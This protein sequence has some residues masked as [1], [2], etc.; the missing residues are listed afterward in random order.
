MGFKTP[1]MAPTSNSSPR[2][3]HAS[4]SAGMHPGMNKMPT[5][6]KA[7]ESA[8]TKYAAPTLKL[9][10]HDAQA[11]M[12]LAGIAQRKRAGVKKK[13][14]LNMKTKTPVYKA[15]KP[16]VNPGSKENP[17][18]VFNYATG[19]PDVSNPKAPRKLVSGAMKGS[20]FFGQ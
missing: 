18:G 4:K 2:P 10:T 3:K 6:R 15:H 1:I 13:F 5:T 8:G 12:T 9:N 11:K 17:S 14:S 20:A 7:A 16:A 19:K